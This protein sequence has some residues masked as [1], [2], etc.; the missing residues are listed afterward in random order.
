MSIARWFCLCALI[1]T[2]V[3]TQAFAGGFQLNEHGANGMSQAGAFAARA[4]DGSAIFFNPAGLGFQSKASV[5]LGTTIIAPSGSFWGPAQNNSNEKIDNVS[6]VFT[7][8]NAYVV[9]PAMER[10]TVGV[11]VMNPYGLG[12]EW[13][14]NWVG[15]YLTVRIELQSFYFTPTV[16]YRITDDLSIGAGFSYVTGTVEMKKKVA[17]ASVAT[18]E[19]PMVVLDMSGTGMGWTA[20]ALYKI[21]PELSVGLSYRSAVTMDADGTAEFD[22]SYAALGLPAGDVATSITL[23]AT[24]FAGIAYKV[25]EDLEIEADLQYIWWSSYDQ[26]KIDFKADNSTSTSPKNYQDT[27]IA[28]IGG[29][30]SLGDLKI[31][32]GYY[33]DHSPVKDEYLEPMLP[34]ANRHGLNLGLGYQISDH[35]NVDLSYLFIKFL[36]RKAENTIPEISFDGTYKTHVNLFGVDLGYTF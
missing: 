32:G 35:I 9:V 23:P 16:S 20:G 31:R 3:A 22:P 4:Y 6:L 36:E 21:S 1:G 12:S 28:R 30:Y 29:E 19:E 18:P 11:G 25:T 8:I 34:D 33:F 10:L 24:G 7:P 14:E 26:L 5:Y 15:R 13:D 2:F 27:Y 17:I